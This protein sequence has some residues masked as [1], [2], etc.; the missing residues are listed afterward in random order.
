MSSIN[1][2]YLL[3]ITALVILTFG[4]CLFNKFVGDDDVILVDNEFHH[5]WKNFPLLFSS[6]YLMVPDK[7]FNGGGWTF[8][9]GSVAYRPVQS[10]TFFLDYWLWKENPFG[11]HLTNVLFHL[12]NSLLLYILLVQILKNASL[13]FLSTL[14]FSVHPLRTEPVANICCR[15]DLVV[16]FFVLLSFIFFIKSEKENDKRNWLWNILSAFFYLLALFSKESAVVL[17][18]LFVLYDIFISHNW[19][20]RKVSEIFLKYSG[21]FLILVF[22]GWIYFYV[23]VNTTFAQGLSLSGSGLV[24]GLTIGWIF[25]K[26]ILLFLFPWTVKVLPP[27]YAPIVSSILEYRAILSL[28][29]I[30]LIC[31]LGY[32]LLKRERGL[33][34]FL[35]FFIVSF[36]PVSN[37]IPI[38]NPM[39]YRFMYLPS[40]GLSVLLAW[41]LSSSL[42]NPKIQR[43]MQ[44]FVVAFC[45]I[46][47][48]TLN[49]SW[50]S[51][52]VSSCAMVKDFPDN[53]FG[54][55]FAGIEFYKIRE[56]KS[57]GENFRKA[58]SLNIHDP[59]AYYSLAI[60]TSDP[61]EAESLFKQSIHDFPFYGLSYVG[62]GRLY[63]FQGKM[64]AALKVL[65][66]GKD[67]MHNY[68][69]Y[70]Y[71]IQAYL[72]KDQMEKAREFCQDAKKYTLD[73][74]QI[75]SLIYFL[76]NNKEIKFPIDVGL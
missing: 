57:A 75:D 60:I 54:Y 30:S 63:L 67:L 20:R 50:K 24:R 8:S 27:F 51:N 71:L 55:L 10:A 7:L 59:R 1:K 76:E 40:I 56:M 64:D 72:M 6:Q 19:Q 39:A 17:I 12:A 14:L 48:V 53:P 49:F 43:I 45:M 11:Y 21:Y 52:F 35:V 73:R 16:C 62:L 2:K 31:F 26:Y 25:T 15:A 18:A 47:T 4:N 41:G 34:F 42:L 46:L 38:A 28:I 70:A 74:L 58:I 9:S 5:S 44:V 65:I 66:K 33:L 37:F 23:F 68:Q 3:I 36:I 61:L 22:Y 13:A 29:V 69:S 32:R